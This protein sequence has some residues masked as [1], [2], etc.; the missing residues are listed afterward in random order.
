MWPYH[1]IAYAQWRTPVLQRQCMEASLLTR[2]LSV[3][4]EWQ[5]LRKTD[6]SSPAILDKYA[7]G[8]AA[9]ALLHPPQVVLELPCGQRPA[10]NE[11]SSFN[12][13]QHNASQHIVTLCGAMTNDVLVLPGSRSICYVQDRLEGDRFRRLLHLRDSVFAYIQSQTTE[14][15]R[16]CCAS[17]FPSTS[18]RPA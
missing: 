15:S 7:V 1:A 18:R 5:E 3:E 6:W 14:L 16:P 8:Q 12:P 10:C 4:A 9:I 13:A 2:K 17:Q 11:P